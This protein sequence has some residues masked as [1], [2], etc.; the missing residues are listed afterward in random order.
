M[1]D[2][3]KSHDIKESVSNVLWGRAAGRRG[4]PPVSCASRYE[5]LVMVALLPDPVPFAA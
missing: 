1:P 5:S 4:L 2:E 3:V